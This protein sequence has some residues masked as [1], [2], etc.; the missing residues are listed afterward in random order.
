MTLRLPRALLSAIEAHARRSH[1]EECCGVMLGPLP[2]DFSAPGRGVGVDEA[3]PL[4]N[5]WE[6]PG[7]GT[8]YQV[9]P[10]R[11]AAL[12]RELRGTGR[13]I[14]GFYHSHPGVPAWPSPFDLARA[15]P[16]LSY[17][18][19]SVAADGAREARS[20]MRSEDGKDFVDEGLEIV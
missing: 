4:D 14:V 6:A 7:R 19:L 3:R 13:G 18:I 5:A 9:E 1:P 20:W 12:E 8:R 11:L 10:A 2:G 16:C 15:W 17:L